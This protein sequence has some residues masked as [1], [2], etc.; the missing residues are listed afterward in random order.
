M[1]QENLYNNQASAEEYIVKLCDEMEGDQDA[2]LEA[3]QFYMRKGEAYSDKA[4]HY[5]RDAYSFGPNNQLIGMTYACVLI[6][7]S[8]FSE[9]FIILNQLAQQGYYPQKCYLLLSI[10]D[11]LQRTASGEGDDCLYQKFKAM[12]LIGYLRE[13]EKIPE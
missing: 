1:E 5:L 8:R 6:Q 3:A 9:A 4:E 10:A 11:D 12:S 7:N 2:L 13:K